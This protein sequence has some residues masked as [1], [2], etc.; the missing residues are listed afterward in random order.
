MALARAGGRDGGRSGARGGG[1]G[2]SGQGRCGRGL[3]GRGR[4][5]RGQGGGRGGVH[6]RRLLVNL[7]SEQAMQDGIIDAAAQSKCAHEITH[8]AEWART[9]HEDWF[10]QRG[11]ETADALDLERENEGLMARRRRV[12]E[13]W[14][15]TLRSARN[16]PVFYPDELTAT[17]V[18]NFVSSQANQTAGSA[19]V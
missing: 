12:K 6:V 4:G 7:A 10:T 18:M 13:G 8:F 14:L 11:R 16:V 19:F 15:A 9:N 3:C 1:R 17:G 2:S 5:G